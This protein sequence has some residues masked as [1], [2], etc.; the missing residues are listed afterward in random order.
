MPMYNLSTQLTD[1]GKK[2]YLFQ[3][4]DLKQNPENVFSEL[5]F[6]ELSIILLFNISVH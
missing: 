2:K 6:Y 4:Y 5:Y 3:N 1:L